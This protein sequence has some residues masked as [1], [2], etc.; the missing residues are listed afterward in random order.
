MGVLNFDARSVAPQVGLDPVPDNW[1]KVVIMKSNIK[2]TNAGDSGMLALEMP[3]I[4]GQFQ[5]R[6]LFWNLNLFNKSQQACEIAQK[7]LSAIC[8]VVGQ[9]NVQDQQT[10]DAATPMLHNIPFYVHAAIGKNQSGAPNNNIVGVRD[11]NG[12]EPG[13]Q[14][15]GAPMAAPAPA[16]QPG[17]WQQPAPQAGAGPAGGSAPG[18]WSPPAPAAPATA[19]G[20]W[21]P[22]QGQP[23]PAAQ[24][25]PAQG[26]W[27]APGPATAPAAPA[28]GG[29]TPPAPGGA[30]PAA[31]P[32]GR[33]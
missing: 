15:Q 23:A 14:G 20:S 31:A 27:Q 13:K 5:G 28:P 25:A 9:F 10:P 30:P 18:G 22:P 32:W 16:Q 33:S 11:I 29:W 2:P 19:P 17:G 21:G 6:T 26:G 1:Y 24:P 12:N 4:E 8:H 3:I 7:Q